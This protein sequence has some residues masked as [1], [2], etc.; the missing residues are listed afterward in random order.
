[1][2]CLLVFYGKIF[3]D[4]LSLFFVE[5]ADLSGSAQ[6]FPAQKWSEVGVQ[7]AIS[8]GGM[9]ACAVDGYARAVSPPHSGLQVLTGQPRI[10]VL[11][12]NKVATF[13]KVEKEE[14]K[15]SQRE[16]PPRGG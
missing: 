1:M 9:Y 12:K 14:D 2:H 4:Q 3:V 16:G 5:D 11:L 8:V 7:D 15:S 10:P 13:A 6:F